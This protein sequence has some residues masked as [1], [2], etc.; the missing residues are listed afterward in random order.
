MTYNN[1]E[2]NNL[3]NRYKSKVDEISFYYKYPSNISH[4]LYLIVP[5]FI[6]KY[7]IRNETTILSCFKEVPIVI[8]DNQSK[9]YQAFYFS[10]PKQVNGRLE[11]IKGIIL[12]N[13]QDITLIE[14]LDNLVHEINH[15]VN[16]VNNEIA[17]DE[18]KIYIRTGI[19]SIIYDK[20]T[21][22]LLSKDK[23]SI[24]EEVINTKQTEEIINIISSFSNYDITNTEI[25][26]TIYSINKTTNNHYKSDAYYLQ[27]IVLKQLIENKT[28]IKTLEELRF[29]GH[30]EEIHNWFD[31]ITGKENSLKEL[32]TILD[33]ILELELE[34]TK[35]KY[36]KGR[37]VNKIKDLNKTALEIVTTFNNNCNYR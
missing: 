9:I 23:E 25:S 13:Y 16:S 19:S 1:E 2:L 33:K 36:F 14:L 5:A 27:S 35:K 22:T 12:N 37:I 26:N 4:L 28:F 24:I 10:K 20:K 15:A 7:G 29:K 3:L 8:S 18:D 32:S 11:T 6:I 31:N 34:L 17:T 30:I 21:L